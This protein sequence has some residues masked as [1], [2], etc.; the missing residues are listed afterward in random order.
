MYKLNLYQTIGESVTHNPELVS[1]YMDYGVD[2]CCGGN[3]T[4]KEAIER[5]TKKIDQLISDAEKAMEQAEL[6]SV[7]SGKIKLSDFSNNQLIDKI[8]ADHHSYLKTELPLLSEL[9]FKILLVHGESHP[10]LFEIHKLF[11]N[12]KTELESHLVKEEILLFP[13]LKANASNCKDLITELEKE[14]DGA[15]DALHKLTDLT[16]H[17]RLPADACTTYEIVYDKLKTLVADMYMHV[18]SENNVLFKRFV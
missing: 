2:F 3:R 5:D 4:V 9:M 12:L 16:D 10:E 15:G 14:H 17:F 1:V 6:V 18:H 11:G 7:N 8:I 13:E